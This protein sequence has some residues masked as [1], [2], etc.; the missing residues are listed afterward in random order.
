M[1]W[2]LLGEKAKQSSRGFSWRKF[3]EYRDHETSE[4]LDG[5]FVTSRNRWRNQE[6][7]ESGAESRQVV[8]HEQ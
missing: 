5:N 6:V 4:L 2:N 3:I 8:S 1:Y 7:Q